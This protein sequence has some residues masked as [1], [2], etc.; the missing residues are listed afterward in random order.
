LRWDTK[1]TYLQVFASDYDDH[2]LRNKISVA[3]VYGGGGSL[4]SEFTIHS[5]KRGAAQPLVALYLEVLYLKATGDQTQ[6][7][8]GDDPA[9]PNEDDTGQQISGIPHDVESLQINVGIR[10]GIGL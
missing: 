5:D 2:L 1:L 4:R 9:S 3:D 6:T 7:W 8:Y 10:I